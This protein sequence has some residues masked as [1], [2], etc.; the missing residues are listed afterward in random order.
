MVGRLGYRLKLGVVVPS[1]NTIVH[2]ETDAMRPHGVTNHIVSL[3]SWAC[4]ITPA[5]P[6]LS[7]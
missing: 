7:R 4:A 6:H 3:G 1:T 5:L 2:P